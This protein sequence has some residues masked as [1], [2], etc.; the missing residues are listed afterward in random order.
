MDF[1]LEFTSEQQPA[2]KPPAKGGR[3]KDHASDHGISSRGIPRLLQRYPSSRIAAGGGK[4]VETE[5]AARFSRR[6]PSFPC[7]GKRSGVGGG[8]RGNQAWRWRGPARTGHW[9]VRSTRLGESGQWRAWPRGAREGVSASG[10]GLPAV[11]HHCALPWAAP[12]R[13]VAAEEERWLSLQGVPH[14]WR[15]LGRAARHGLPFAW[16][17]REWRPPRAASCLPGESRREKANRRRS[18]EAFRRF[19]MVACSLLI[20]ASQGSGL[21]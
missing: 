8:G 1:C 7:M 21:V 16:G 14:S 2:D 3:E 12:R 15:A 6:R 11:I 4:T 9:R 5:C 20:P 10:E 18:N 19:C 17:S 13:R